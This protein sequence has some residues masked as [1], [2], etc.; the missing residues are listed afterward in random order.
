MKVGISYLL[1]SRVVT[2]DAKSFGVDTDEGGDVTFQAKQ[3]HSF[4]DFNI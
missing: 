1:T 3:G 4:V 2:V